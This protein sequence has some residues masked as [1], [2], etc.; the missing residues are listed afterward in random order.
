MQPRLDAWYARRPGRLE[1]YVWLA[2]TLLSLGVSYAFL[3]QH[4]RALLEN[5]RNSSICWCGNCAI[6]HCSGQFFQFMLVWVLPAWLS[7]KRVLATYPPS[8]PLLLGLSI[9]GLSI[10]ILTSNWLIQNM[11]RYQ[12]T[13]AL[14]PFALGR[15]VAVALAIIWLATILLRDLLANREAMQRY[16]RL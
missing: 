13:A 6:S 10:F 15:S 4:D 9:A 5:F 1:R 12:S 2:F 8:S 3:R 11:H 16:P 7:S 14:I